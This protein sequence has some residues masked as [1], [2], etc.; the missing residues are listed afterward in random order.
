MV[1][2]S[3]FLCTPFDKI[4]QTIQY[5]F[6]LRVFSYDKKIIWKISFNFQHQSIVTPLLNTSLKKLFRE[7]HFLK[8]TV[9]MNCKFCFQ[10]HFCVPPMMNHTKTINFFSRQQVTMKIN[11]LQIM[12]SVFYHR[13]SVTSLITMSFKEAC[14]KKSF[15]KTHFSEM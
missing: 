15:M 6:F 12:T 13:F 7:T 4:C 5:S 10:N 2:L 3:S 11:F 1:C 14:I 9:S 8:K